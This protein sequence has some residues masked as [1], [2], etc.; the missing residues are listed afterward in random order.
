[1][2]KK[3]KTRNDI[4]CNNN[5]LRLKEYNY[6]KKLPNNNGEEYS[7]LT[8]PTSLSIEENLEETAKFFDMFR[9]EL[10]RITEVP[11]YIYLHLDNTEYI[12][13]EA[14]MHLIAL[15]NDEKNKQNSSLLGIK[16]NFPKT[17]DA[18]RTLK[19]CGFFDYVKVNNDTGR[20]IQTK[21]IKIRNG[22]K[23]DPNTV[24][25][26]CMFAQEYGNLN[27]IETMPIYEIII[28]MMKNTFNHAYIKENKER[29]SSWYVFAEETHNY[30]KFAFL[31]T[32]LGIPR[33]LRKKIKEAIFKPQDCE[34]LESALTGDEGRSRTKLRNRGNGLPQIFENCQKEI[35]LDMHIVSG[36]A[37]CVITPENKIVRLFDIE[38]RMNGTLYSWKIKKG[39][40]Q[41]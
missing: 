24:K 35:F 14:L 23:V 13:A 40:E 21:K 3:E 26:L 12:G 41:D 31:D 2:G 32:G 19:S 36:K 11:R 7:Y 16:G 22:E 10:R 1:M 4:R 5:K 38:K 17:E 8:L 34:L 30:I 9:C 29:R 37:Y 27:R 15:I 20:L 39:K 18:M 33:T 25:M 6:S 28:E